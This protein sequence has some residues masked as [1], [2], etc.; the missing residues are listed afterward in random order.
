MIP[1]AF[2]MPDRRDFL[3]H[4]LR[5]RPE[6]KGY[7]G[8]MAA[9]SGSGDLDDVSRERAIQGFA[10]LSMEA[11]AGSDADLY[12]LLISTDVL[13]EGVNLQQSSRHPNLSGP[14]EPELIRPTS[15]RNF[16]S[17]KVGD[18]MVGHGRTRP[19]TA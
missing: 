7:R 10:P 8:R 18:T 5:T 9:V 6:L 14:T 17:V 4:E 16:L 1:R 19:T 15:G 3:D 2:H 11:P 13:A 12:D